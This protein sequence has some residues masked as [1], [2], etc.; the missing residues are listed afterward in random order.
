VSNRFGLIRYPGSKAKLYRQVM[1]FMPDEI[2]L[3]L[4]S[5]LDAW[6]YREPF[7]GSGALGFR[8]MERISP[9]CRVWLNDRDY[10]LV[11]LWKAVQDTPRELVSMIRG[12]TPSPDK[13]YAFKESDG[14]TDIDPVVAGFRKLATHQMS[15]SG[16][17]VMSGGC[18]GGRDQTNSLYTVDCRWNPIRLAE[19]VLN[20]HKQMKA[21]GRRLEITC[22]DFS[23]V[24]QRTGERCFVYMDPPYV[25]KGPVLYKHA[26]PGVSEHERLAAC[27][28]KLN[29]PWVLSYDDHP[30]VREL[31]QDCGIRNV[32]ITYSNATHAKG[33]RPKN[34][35]VIITPAVTHATAD[36]RSEPQ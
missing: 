20:R 3:G 33:K 4:W 16:F 18:L 1:E 35:E 17:G 24:L 8:I 32:A 22:K 30:L 27:I 29:C 34:S 9:R 10:W 15:V 13:F 7:F 2:T 36:L 31:Y 6:E 11:C 14:A 19:N 25:D 21:F 28:R 23:E 5:D 12:F 26:M